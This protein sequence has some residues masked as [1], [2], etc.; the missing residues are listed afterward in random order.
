MKANVDIQPVF[1]TPVINNI[2]IDT[3]N[4]YVEWYLSA[5]KQSG[6]IYYEYDIYSR[7]RNMLMDARQFKIN[8]VPTQE[9]K[10]LN[11]LANRVYADNK[12]GLVNLFQKRIYGFELAKN[13]YWV[14]K[15][16]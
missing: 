6:A 4:E 14:F 3:E 9:A 7:R 8:Q 15:K 1:I 12:L 11:A 10:E 13:Q 16:S 2:Y 5:P